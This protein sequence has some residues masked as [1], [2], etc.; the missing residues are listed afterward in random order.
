MRIAFIFVALLLTACDEGKKFNQLHAMCEQSIPFVQMGRCLESSLDQQIPDWRADQ[1]A[2]YV[3]TYIAWLDAAGE[4][5][6]SGDMREYDMRLGASELLNRMR[7]EARAVRNTDLSTN[8]ALFLSGL[9][10]MNGGYYNQPPPQQTT[11]IWSP[12][13]RPISCTNTGTVISCF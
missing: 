12:G 4:R 9:A 11:T 6:T 13:S 10:I 1:H 3:K 5:V 8:M 2:E 7:A